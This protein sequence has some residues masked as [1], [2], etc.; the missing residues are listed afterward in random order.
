MMTS[1]N[2]SLLRESVPA[3][4]CTGPSKRYTSPDEES[5]ARP[6]RCG[7]GPIT[8]HAFG[9]SPLQYLLISPSATNPV[10]DARSRGLWTRRTPPQAPPGALPPTVGPRQ[11]GKRKKQNRMQRVPQRG[12]TVTPPWWSEGHPG[13]RRA[14]ACDS[15]PPAHPRGT[16]GP[17]DATDLPPAERACVPPSPARAVALPGGVRVACVFCWLG[18]VGGCVGTG[19]VSGACA[20]AVSVWWCICL[21]GASCLAVEAAFLVVSLSSCRSVLR[22]RTAFLRA[23]FFL[24][25]GDTLSSA[26]HGRCLFI[27]G[28]RATLCSGTLFSL[29]SPPPYHHHS[30]LGAASLC[31][32]D[33]YG[34]LWVALPG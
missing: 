8:T 7:S 3:Q 10:A 29:P 17:C 12:P 19:S 22:W 28:K 27:L 9:G 5:A 2:Y 20:L 14:H 11:V 32:R 23:A 31:G 24:F 30:P 21:A 4:Q 1:G 6:R 18:V 26:R 16:R 34:A 13:S 33:H 15:D 25:P